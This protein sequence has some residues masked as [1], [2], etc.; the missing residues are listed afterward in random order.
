M[1][2]IEGGDKGMLILTEI[3]N[4]EHQVMDPTN[5]THYY[6]RMSTSWKIPLN[7]SCNFPSRIKKYTNASIKK[8]EVQVG[9]LEKQ[10]VDQ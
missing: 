10:M 4:M 6:M 2:I 3:T 9:H 1:F 8:L 7:N 5:K